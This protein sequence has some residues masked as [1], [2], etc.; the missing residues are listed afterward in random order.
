MYDSIHTD[1]MD[2]TFLQPVNRVCASMASILNNDQTRALQ[3]FTLHS[4]LGLFEGVR[5]LLSTASTFVSMT[6]AADCL[7]NSIHQ[8]DS[9]VET[10]MAK[11]DNVIPRSMR[12]EYYRKIYD[13]LRLPGF[14]VSN[15][16]NDILLRLQKQVHD[17]PGLMFVHNDYALDAVRDI[18][19]E[20][21]N[22][23]IWPPMSL[24]CSDSDLSNS[25]V[26]IIPKPVS[27]F[28]RCAYT[29]TCQGVCGDAIA[30]FYAE[31]ALV[32]NPV[33]PDLKSPI[34]IPSQSWVSGDI[35]HP[36][37]VQDYSNA[38][39][40]KC[41]RWIVVLGIEEINTEWRLILL[42]HTAGV[43]VP[44]QEAFSGRISEFHTERFRLPY[45]DEV[46]DAYR[47][48]NEVWMGPLLGNDG[49]VG[50]VIVLA[51][52]GF[53]N[54]VYVLDVDSRYTMNGYWLVTSVGAT[55]P[56]V[57]L[58]LAKVVEED[59]QLLAPEASY[60]YVNGDS[61]FNTHNFIK[62]VVV[63]AEEQEGGFAF[64][65]VLRGFVQ[66]LNSE[67]GDNSLTSFKALV[68]IGR[69]PGAAQAYCHAYQQ[70][71]GKNGMMDFL[72]SKI[73]R[74]NNILVYDQL[75][76]IGIWGKTGT[77]YDT[78]EITQVSLA[79]TNN[80]YFD[81]VPLPYP[82]IT[83]V[84]DESVIQNTGIFARRPHIYTRKSM[85]SGQ[86][87]GALFSVSERAPFT[88]I[89]RLL[90]VRY[91]SVMLYP[92]W[93]TEVELSTS[94]AQCTCMSV[95]G[96]VF[97]EPCRNANC[98][99]L[100]IQR[101]VAPFSV[102]S[103]ARIKQACDYMA[104]TGCSTMRLQKF[105]YAAQRCATMRCVGTV[106][107]VNSVACVLGSF[108]RETL[109]ALSSNTYNAWY[110]AVEIGG[111]LIRVWKLGENVGT[112]NLEG[113]SN[114]VT[115]ALCQYKD[116][117]A[118]ASAFVPS[119]LTVMWVAET[120]KYY[121]GVGVDDITRSE[122]KAAKDLFSPRELIDRTRENIATTQMVYQI[123]LLSVIVF[124]EAEILLCIVGDIITALSGGVVRVLVHEGSDSIC[125]MSMDDSNNVLDASTDAHNLI[126]QRIRMMAI[127]PEPGHVNVDGMSY[128]DMTG[129]FADIFTLAITSVANRVPIPR[130]G[131]VRAQFVFILHTA[132]T[133]T[134]WVIG[135]IHGAASIALVSQDVACE[136]KLLNVENIPFCVCGDAE[137]EIPATRSVATGS[138]GALWCVGLLRLRTQD[139][140]EVFVYNPYTLHDLKRALDD[141]YMVRY[142]ACLRNPTTQQCFPP[143][144]GEVLTYFNK[145]RTS[146]V[147]VLARC[148]ANYAQ[149]KWDAGVFALFEND[150][151][152]LAL[153]TGS[154]SQLRAD[155]STAVSQFSLFV[156]GEETC[157]PENIVRQ[158]IAGGPNLNTIQACTA[159]ALKNNVKS[160]YTIAGY[161]SYTKAWGTS[162]SGA[163]ACQYM[164]G[165]EI[166]KID[167]VKRCQETNAYTCGSAHRDATT[168]EISLSWSDTNVIS[169]QSVDLYEVEVGTQGLSRAQVQDAYASV[170]ACL[171]DI[172]SSQSISNL[173][174]G[175]LDKIAFD[176][177]SAEGDILHQY[178]DCVFLGP[179][180]LQNI[181]PT[182]VP[183]LGV[184]ELTYS[185][186]GKSIKDLENECSGSTVTDVYSGN[187]ETIRVNTCGSPAR[188]SAITYVL[189]HVLVASGGSNMIENMIIERL[190]ELRNNVSDISKF[191]CSQSAT[192]CCK[193]T[194]CSYYP[195]MQTSTLISATDI[196]SQAFDESVRIDNIG[197]QEHEVSA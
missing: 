1:V 118:C 31:K 188:I 128:T 82:K 98:L 25:V 185:R 18:P 131:F 172:L 53:S 48:V 47:V 77:Q 161:F 136:P 10:V 19:S 124:K 14:S 16:C 58:Q 162:K 111:T 75:G 44:V 27:S 169:T 28:K 67:V 94:D 21:M 87:V 112:V 29:P 32:G 95:Y 117:L 15:T 114:M 7:C 45:E 76:H 89:Y 108:S 9:S 142:L 130:A 102:K 116:I 55:A 187:N 51:W 168:C 134:N 69:K 140:D 180:P 74:Y 106:I 33:K 141:G 70:S 176:I 64:V 113:L 23:I 164:T 79:I 52:Q 86:A 104:C 115:T 174:Q 62:G 92:D 90:T 60:M 84:D 107:N 189:R 46:D 158:C 192:A 109:E 38:I 182:G 99:R 125:F 100:G 129:S 3:T 61:A 195:E 160:D 30:A 26:S 163:D 17:A 148:R 170:Q 59:L 135:L 11:C 12:M 167:S 181:L 193:G 194:E 147:T 150:V 186:Y 132:I 37:A 68:R 137:Y 166:T 63:P 97:G 145:R 93:V 156:C 144:E 151:Q 88:K 36:V 110:N 71:V 91:S 4:C 152:T 122:I 173:I 96:T 121:H 49:I 24:T 126:M 13:A 56:G 40:S 155:I 153:N 20:I 66:I 50:R 146:A 119:T 6:I 73:D 183:G 101:N 42:C 179:T 197:L 8:Y 139:G 133:A 175:R 177:F 80:T 171:L 5:V 54:G 191:A 72:L 34:D 41:I 120:A 22:L 154:T 157:P 65:G 2:T 123:L 39:N 165:T 85:Y 159:L 190:N 83:I 138:D 57:C 35:I 127:G 196:I 103:T 184:E 143:I 81:L 105:C 43:G 78:T 149:R 178:M